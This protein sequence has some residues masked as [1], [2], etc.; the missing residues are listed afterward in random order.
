MLLGLT[1]VSLG[2][3]AIF[4][5]VGVIH[6]IDVFRASRVEVVR[7]EWVDITL[8]G[9]A[10]L[11]GV[12]LGAGDVIIFVMRSNLASIH[13][14]EGSQP[15]SVTL[16]PLN[17]L[18]IE[19]PDSFSRFGQ[20]SRFSTIDGAVAFIELGLLICLSPKVAERIIP[21]CISRFKWV[22]LAFRLP[23]FLRHVRVLDVFVAS[24]CPFISRL[25][26][27]TL[28]IKAVQRISR[29]K[30]LLL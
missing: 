24:L 21:H 11:E 15:A 23:S 3:G 30:L 29:R 5:T 8:A 26:L 12:G 9:E 2:H 6:R 25:S 17:V 28:D 13:P 7:L 16:R 22:R 4:K 27:G 18:C 1:E 14:R 10:S 20:A 19:I